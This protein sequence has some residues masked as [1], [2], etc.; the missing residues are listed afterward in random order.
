MPRTPSDT[1]VRIALVIAYAGATLYVVLMAVLHVVQPG[2]I[3]DGTISKYALGPGGWMLQAAFIAAGAG[4]AGVA[5]LWSGARAI[6]SWVTAAAFLVMGLFVIDSV[7][8]TEVV[9]IHGAL[10]TGAFFVV[11]LLTTVLMFL[12]RGRT[13]SAWLRT[14]PFLAPVLVLAGFFIPGLVGAVLFRAWTLSLVLWVILTARE[15]ARAGRRGAASTPA[16]SIS[17]A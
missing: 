5:L 15:L 7:G 10:H 2:L 3:D 8:P 16:H 17:G 9:S 13:D 1:R 11:V 6:L 12:H 14:L 4:Y